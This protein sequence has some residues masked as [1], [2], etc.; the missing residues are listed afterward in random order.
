MPRTSKPP[1]KEQMP[2]WDEPAPAPV[3]QPKPTDPDY[4]PYN[5]LWEPR[6]PALPP[7]PPAQRHSRTSVE[8]ARLLG[9]TR[10]GSLR[11]AIYRW[12]LERPAGATDE[13]G[14]HALQM[15]GN[16]YRP[17]RIELQEAGLVV[18]SKTERL[19]K[20][21]RRA[22]VWVAVRPPEEAA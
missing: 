17:R 1:P 20:N 16:T 14:Q 2:L 19:T 8:A 15:D 12:L 3:R 4:R 21:Q 13:E 6:P 22:V 10:A 9:G 11:A 5:P 7:L 18:D